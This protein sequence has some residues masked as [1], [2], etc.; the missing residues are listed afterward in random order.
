MRERPVGRGVLSQSRGTH[1]FEVLEHREEHHAAI[2]YTVQRGRRRPNG[3]V[4]KWTSVIQPKPRRKS[5]FPDSAYDFWTEN[6]PSHT[7]TSIF[8]DEAI[9]KG[10]LLAVFAKKMSNS[11]QY[12]SQ[13]DE[14]CLFVDSEFSKSYSH[15]VILKI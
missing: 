11:E 13:L 10:L 12:H 8:Q 5:K 15:F 3:E 9:L 14:I 2:H 1:E 4:A 6:G 7:A